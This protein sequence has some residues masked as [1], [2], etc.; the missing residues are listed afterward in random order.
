MTWVWL[1]LPLSKRRTSFSAVLN[2]VGGWRERGGVGGE[3]EDVCVERASRE[4]SLLCSPL[5][6]PIEH[7]EDLLDQVGLVAVTQLPGHA[8][9]VEGVGGKER[10]DGEL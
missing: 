2:L 4:P 6:V 10:A 7:S 3:G 9:E 1:N 8:L 5:L